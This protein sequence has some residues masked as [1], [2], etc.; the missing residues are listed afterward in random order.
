MDRESGALPEGKLGVGYG[1]ELVSHK[2]LSPA[3]GGGEGLG[4]KEEKGPLVKVV[5]RSYVGWI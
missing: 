2:T 3:Q 4:Q 1:R 5:S